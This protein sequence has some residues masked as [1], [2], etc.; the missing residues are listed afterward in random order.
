MCCSWKVSNKKVL[1]KKTNWYQNFDL[2]WLSDFTWL[3]TFSQLWLESNELFW[4]DSIIDFTQLHKALN[5]ISITE[6]S[7][8]YLLIPNW[9]KQHRIRCSQNLNLV[10][11]LFSMEDSSLFLKYVFDLKIKL[12]KIEIKSFMFKMISIYWFSLCHIWIV[13]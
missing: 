4:L 1:C 7:Y 5:F 10:R 8:F 3:S 12:K 9:T 2:T 13:K 6:L 11:G